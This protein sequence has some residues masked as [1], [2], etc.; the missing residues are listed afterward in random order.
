MSKRSW[1]FYL[2]YVVFTITLGAFQYGYHTGELNTPQDIISKCVL[3]NGDPVVDK[4]ILPACLPMTDARYSLVVA[5]LLAGGLVGA[6][7]TSYYGGRRHTLMCANGFLCVGSLMM[8]VA[9]NVP[10][11]MMGRFVA[12]VG[13]GMATVVVPTYISECVPKSTRG[14]FGTLNQL[15]IVVGILASQITSIILPGWRWILA[16]AVF[17]QWEDL[18]STPIL[19]MPE[20][21]MCTSAKMCNLIMTLLSAYFMDR[22]GR[23]TLF[24]ISSAS[25]ACCSILLGWSI[26]HSYDRT[27]GLAITAFVAA[28]A[29]GLGPIPFLMIPELVE[30]SAVASAGSIALASNMICN[31]I[32]SAGFMAFRDTIGQGQVF[33]VFAVILVVCTVLAVFYLPETKNKSA[34]QIVRSRWAVAWSPGKQHYS[35]V[36]V[37]NGAASS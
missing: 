4:G 1:T 20:K 18:G 21:T 19:I 15:A 8:A 35:L 23:R 25:M 22:A 6:L 33:Y 14:L 37:S 30:T 16:T 31:F 32:V 10:L 3:K 27:S 29:I 34:E 9:P 2:L 26:Q 12:G 13:G 5:M 11:L 24:L 28:F 36:S 7:T 17:H